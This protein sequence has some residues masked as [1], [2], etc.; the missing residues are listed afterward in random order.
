[1]KPRAGP[2]EDG[3]RGT[4]QATSQELALP[5]TQTAAL[6]CPHQGLLPRNGGWGPAQPVGLLALSPGWAAH[7]LTR[8]HHPG[9]PPAW[10]SLQLVQSPGRRPVLLRLSP[11]PLSFIFG[12]GY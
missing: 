4:A 2:S 10:C 6:P 5:G 1:M 11:S 9:S 7:S 3:A 12:M 8:T